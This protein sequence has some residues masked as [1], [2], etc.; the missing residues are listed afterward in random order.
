MVVAVATYRVPSGSNVIITDAWA[1][2]ALT[3]VVD[4]RAS[5]IRVSLG[6]HSLDLPVIRAAFGP[7]VLASSASTFALSGPF[8]ELRRAPR[9]NENACA[10]FVPQDVAGAVVL[11]RR[12][13]CTFQEKATRAAE[14]GAM[15]V[16]VSNDEEA[17]FIPTAD[18][19][20]GT[21]GDGTEPDRP[22]VPLLLA[23]NSSGIRLER[24]LDMVR[25]ASA[26]GAQAGAQTEAVKV[27]VVPAPPPQPG[28][29]EINGYRLMN[30]VL[31][32]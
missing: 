19:T 30:V 22:L 28:V 31:A 26:A 23:A 12:G 29:V 6:Q 11:V 32:R 8:L 9:A 20:A 24:L 2:H 17:L 10:A 13:L 25:N 4:A 3:P 14:A 15:G 5:G 7:D 1:V 16:I 27:K 18:E 21:G